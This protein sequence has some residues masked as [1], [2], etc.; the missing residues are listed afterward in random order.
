MSRPR[1]ARVSVE[2]GL[3]SCAVSA[4]LSAPPLASVFASR[5]RASASPFTLGDDRL[6][7]QAD[8][9][10]DSTT[11]QSASRCDRRHGK[12]LLCH[13]PA[14]SLRPAAVGL[15]P[16]TVWSGNGTKPPTT[17]WSRMRGSPGTARPMTACRRLLLPS[18]GRSGMDRGSSD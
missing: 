7:G 12:Q 5:P 18:P 6:P 8:R 15:T 17:S 11:R 2:T 14:Q 1:V 16:G 13:R 10:G 3:R 9:L 4:C